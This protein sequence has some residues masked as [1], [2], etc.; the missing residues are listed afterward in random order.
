[1]YCNRSESYHLLSFPPPSAA[2]QC[3]EL[4]AIPHWMDILG[5]QVLGPD[6]IHKRVHNEG[7][8]YGKV[9]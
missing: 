4:Q 3:I 2:K 6:S 8:T 7:W 1:M 9:D 5:A